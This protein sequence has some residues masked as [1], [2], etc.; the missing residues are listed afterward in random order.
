MLNFCDFIQVFVFTTNH[1]LKCSLQ[2]YKLSY[3]AKGKLLY[4]FYA[5]LVKI[6]ETKQAGLTS[7]YLRINK[8]ETFYLCMI[9]FN[10]IIR[11]RNNVNLCE[12]ECGQNNPDHTCTFQ[13]ASAYLRISSYS[14]IYKLYTPGK[15]F[16]C[17]PDEG[18]RVFH[19]YLQILCHTCYL[20]QGRIKIT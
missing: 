2:L 10:Q 4:T 11:Y 14:L 3:F 15:V 13:Y 9:P 1:H 17:T 19:M 6:T 7:F 12:F 18:I 8:R 20:T 5:Y 16:S